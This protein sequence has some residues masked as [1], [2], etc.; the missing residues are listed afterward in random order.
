VLVVV[1]AALAVVALLPQRERQLP[2]SM[3]SLSTTHVTLYPQ[4][5]PRAVWTFAAPEVEYDPDRRETTLLDLSDGRRVVDG[6]TDFTL[7]SDRIVIDNQDNLRGDHIRA[8]LI[9][10]DADLDMVA[11]GGREVLIDQRRGRFEVP[12]VT[13]SSAEGSSVFEDMRISFDLT[14]FEAG[15]PGTVGYSEFKVASPAGA[16]IPKEQP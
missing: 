14:E 10:E 16:P 12:R 6:S 3:L 1:I 7:T 13:L 2:S 4:A 9:R 15:G 8:H 5:D 11:K